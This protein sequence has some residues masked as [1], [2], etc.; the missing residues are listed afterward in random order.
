LEAALGGAQAVAD[1]TGSRAY[2]RFTGNQIAR[3][4]Q[5][6][7]DRYAA[8]ERIALVSSFMASLLTGDYAPIDWSDGA[9]MNL[10]DLRRRDWAPDAL[11][12]TGPDLSAKLG[13]IVPSHA[14]VG[15]VHRYYQERYGFGPRC[16]VIAF[17][18]D[19]PNSLAGLRLQRPGE[20]AVSLGTS[21]TLFGSVAEPSPS[22]REGHVF[23]NPVDPEA[24]MV[25]IVRQNGSL[26]REAVRN[27]CAGG[28]WE[29]FNALLR[30]SG[31]GNGGQIGLYFEE[32]EITPP[33]QRTGAFRFDPAG[34]AVDAFGPEVEVRAVVEGQFLALRSHG[35]RIG[36]APTRLLA[37]GGASANRD[38]LRI[39]GDV[40]GVPVYVAEQ[41]DSASLGAAYRALHGWRCAE[42]QRF[43][44]FAEIMAATQ[45][46]TL[47]CRPDAA[48]CE[49]Y[50]GMVGRY[51][52]LEK[53][54]VGS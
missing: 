28:S 8:T 3:I 11:L 37:T 38:I 33:T 40:F 13:A 4:R 23:A 1:L 22:G 27:R 45:D 42:R 20:I 43:V 2:E 41:S 39:A 54:V 26:T 6:Q 51:E 36:L 29:Q 18:G 32:P 44:P 24:Y 46:F 7:P 49:V 50:S 15:T 25:M 5:E 16:R 35:A 9:G 14:A 48:A 31:P 17:S 34:Q 30:K 47:A 19:N 53:T 21:D 10:M 52:A 12:H